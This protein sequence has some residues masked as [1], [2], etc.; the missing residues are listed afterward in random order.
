MIRSGPTPHRPLACSSLP[1]VWFAR[2][3]CLGLLLL[4]SLPAAN[5][6]ARAD[7]TRTQTIQLRRG[8]N[9]V[10]LEVF[11][12]NSAPAKVFANIP[13][14]IVASFQ[15][16]STPAQFMNHPTADLYK[17]RDWG[18]WY[19]S[20]RPDAFLSTLHAIYGQQSYL[21]HARED[22]SWAV[23]G[24]VRPL[25]TRWEANAFNF[26][27]FSVS[28][29]GAPTF[30]QFF[31]GSPAHRHNKL[32]RLTDGVWRRVLDP[33]A[34][35]MRSGEAFWIL[36]EGNSKYQ[37]PLTVE[38]T[39]RYGVFLVSGSDAV[40]LR[41][42]LDHPITPTVHHVPSGAESVPLSL[43]IQVIGDPTAPVQRVAVP[44]PAGAW[45]EVLPP[46]E[47]SG[48]ISIPLELRREDAAAF[49]Q[50]SLLKISTDLG[51]ETWLPVLGLRKD[52][53]AQ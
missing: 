3:L 24:A 51:T 33:S 40:T 31:A 6:T 20:R 47:Q 37:G 50:S 28:T 48:K 1:P 18:V 16:K 34:E 27:G 44:R 11:P 41:N 19:S 29:S 17:D 43:V 53:E 12:S 5:S 25:E 22:Y 49:A 52:L 14:D 36:C 23:S 4:L 35:A 46:L 10:F 42:Q 39:S 8:W 7:V 38:T 26:V 9:A 30:A 13:V 2:G 32:Y 15:G 21:V 45:S